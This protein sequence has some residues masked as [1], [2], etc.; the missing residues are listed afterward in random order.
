[1]NDN[2]KELQPI[3]WKNLKIGDRFEKHINL[4][5]CSYNSSYEIKEI[6]HKTLE[7]ISCRVIGTNQFDH[8]IRQ[9][10]DY[11]NDLVSVGFNFYKVIASENYPIKNGIKETKTSYCNHSNK[12]KNHA[13]GTLFWYCP[14]CKNDLGDVK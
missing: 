2:S 7:I 5:Q 14:A 4:P 9:S 3:D 11:F 1:M 12:Y 8:K 10:F 6:D 13:G